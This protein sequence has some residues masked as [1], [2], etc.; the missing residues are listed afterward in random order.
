MMF[1]NSRPTFHPPDRSKSCTALQEV[2]QPSTLLLDSGKSPGRDC[3]GDHLGKNHPARSG[4][5][6]ACPVTGETVMFQKLR[7][8]SG[9]INENKRENPPG[10]TQ[11]ALASFQVLESRWLQGCRP[12]CCRSH[13]CWEASA[14]ISENESCDNFRHPN[15]CQ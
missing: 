13:R 14:G 9:S 7:D 11:A 12:H 5:F 10:C 1:Q 8:A 2:W 15:P 6:R 4:I 3:F